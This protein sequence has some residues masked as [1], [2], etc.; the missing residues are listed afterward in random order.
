MPACHTRPHT[1]CACGLLLAQWGPHGGR[2][3][4]PGRTQGERAPGGHRAGP[5]RGGGL[6]VLVGDRARVWRDCSG[7]PAAHS[8]QETDGRG[9]NRGQDAS[10]WNQRG[11]SE[12]EDFMRAAHSNA[13]I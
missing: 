2:W 8:A 10:K 11:E 1:D 3:V 12:G 13:S 6:T 4:G 7:S 5:S 9:E